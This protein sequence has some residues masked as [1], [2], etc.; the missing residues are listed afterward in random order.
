MTGIENL[1]GMTTEQL[2]LREFLYELPELLAAADGEPP[3]YRQGVYSVVA[4]LENCLDTFAVDQSRF[5]R[6][7]PNV[8]A[9]FAGKAS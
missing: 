1:D 3:A 5:A 8:D 2:M 9:W 4:M 6:R 7:M